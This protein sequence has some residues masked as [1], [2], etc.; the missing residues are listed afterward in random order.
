MRKYSFYE[1]IPRYIKTGSVGDKMN[2]KMKKILSAV[3]ILVVALGTIS[4]AYADDLSDIKNQQSQVKNDL[5]QL[6]DSI[7]AQKAEVAE[8]DKKIKAKEDELAESEAKIQKAE[9]EIK[10][11]QEEIDSQ[12]ENLGARLRTMYKNGSVGFIDVILGSSSFS[13]LMSNISMLQKIYEGDQE[14]LTYLEEQHKAMQVKREQ[15]SAELESQKV[16]K[17]DLETQRAEAK[18]K[19]DAMQGEINQLQ[20]KLEELNAEADRITG[21]IIEQQD[22]DKDYEGSGRMAWPT[23]SRYITSPFGFRV[24]PVTGIP[25]GHTGIDI[26][27]GYGTNVYAAESGVVMMAQWFGGYGNAVTIDHGDG[28]STLY[29]HNS[30]LCVSPGQRVTKGQV[31]AKCGSTGISTGP[32]VHFEVRIG[33][34]PVDPMGYL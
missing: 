1:K 31:I 13:E 29:G 18:K 15:I 25:T 10:R 17:A 32:H 16:V 7:E 4:L 22:P 27:A 8:I 33:G 20:S 6:A 28:I 5:A 26:G 12:K 21:T 19:T 24:H 3:M 14:T 23:D 9:A 11:M 34:S 30:S 2:S